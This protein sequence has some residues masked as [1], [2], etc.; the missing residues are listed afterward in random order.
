MASELLR[1]HSAENCADRRGYLITLD[2]RALRIE[3]HI[4]FIEVAM[5]CHQTMLI[6]ERNSSPFPQRQCDRIPLLNA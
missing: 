1:R 5:L 2:V 4:V 3:V 6:I